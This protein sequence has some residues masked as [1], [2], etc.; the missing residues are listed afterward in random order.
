MLGPPGQGGGFVSSDPEPIGA[1]TVTSEAMVP[2]LHS[3]LR[4]FQDASS[5]ALGSA[6]VAINAATL[7]CSEFGP[8]VAWCVRRLGGRASP[9]RGVNRCHATW[10]QGEPCRSRY[11]SKL[12]TGCLLFFNVPWYGFRRSD[13]RRV[14]W[15]VGSRASAIPEVAHWNPACPGL[16]CVY[17]YTLRIDRT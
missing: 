16:L 2:T 13:W 4:G 10:E 9:G 5:S 7:P 11:P 3:R 12:P 8:N 14:A 15:L 6:G 1:N 17:V